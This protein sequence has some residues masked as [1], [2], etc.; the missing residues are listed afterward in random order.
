M[1]NPVYVGTGEVAGLVA[2]TGLP[3]KE[4]S[5]LLG[6]SPATLNRYKNG[7]GT[8]PEEVLN[9]LRRL[10]GG[11][12]PEVAMPKVPDAAQLAHFPV[13]MLIEELARRVRGG[14]LY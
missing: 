7:V 6:I 12:R 8:M 4:V 13:T 3:K 5:Q 2:R 10:A 9:T 11:Q 14:Q 1:G